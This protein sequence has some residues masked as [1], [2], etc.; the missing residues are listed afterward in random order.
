MTET[1]QETTICMCHHMRPVVFAC[2]DEVTGWYHVSPNGTLEHSTQPCQAGI[3]RFQVALPAN[4]H[5]IGTTVI[6][7]PSEKTINEQRGT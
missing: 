7:D 3:N 6:G 4:S 1:R 5:T 2:L